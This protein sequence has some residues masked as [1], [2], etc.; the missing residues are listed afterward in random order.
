MD[1][2][3]AIRLRA[4]V[5][6]LKAVGVPDGDLEQ[7]LDAGRRAPSGKNRQP[8]DFIVV[9]EAETIR[10]LAEAQGCLGDVSLIVLVVGKPEESVYWLEDVSAATENMLLA[11]TALGYASVW[12]EGTLLRQEDRWKELLGVPPEMRLMVALP[13]GKAAGEPTQ[14]PKR[15]LSEMVHY[16]RYGRR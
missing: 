4:S 11:I 12:I 13:I 10:Q 7:I 6:N 1:T 9:R 8:L 15:P 3:E 5:R 14:A 16:E 2:F